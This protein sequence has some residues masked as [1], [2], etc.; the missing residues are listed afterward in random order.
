MAC[1]V[2]QNVSEGMEIAGKV[3]GKP[4]PPKCLVWAS[5]FLRTLAAVLTLVAA[6]VMGTARET[7]SVPFTLIPGAPPLIVSVPAKYHYSS[8]F[9][10]L[11]VANVIASVYAFLSLILQAF[12]K[13]SSLLL[14]TCDVV[15]FGLLFSSVGASGA[16]GVVAHNGNSHVK[17]N[18]VCD[19]FDQFCKQVG[20]ATLVAFFG[21]LTFLLL[22]FLSLFNLHR[23][24][25]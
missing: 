8:A 3:G 9:V 19:V 21:A 1:H 10:Y 18:K 7:K 25:P 23:R 11:L 15:M 12:G 16:I 14:C 4:L 2:K 13:R 6:A 22:L 5:F 20:A 17:W 24:S